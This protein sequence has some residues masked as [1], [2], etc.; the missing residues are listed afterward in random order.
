M[1]RRARS[2]WS[3]CSESFQTGRNTKR[4]KASSWP[5]SNRSPA[6]N[7]RQG[8]A[9]SGHRAAAEVREGH[10]AAHATD[11]RCRNEDRA[12]EAAQAGRYAGGR[13]L[14][15]RRHHAGRRE[16][17]EHHGEG[18][19]VTFWL[20]VASIEELPLVL[21]TVRELADRVGGRVVGD[22]NGAIARI[23]GIEESTADTLTFATDE[24]I[25][26]PRSR[27]GLPPCWSMPRSCSAPAIRANRCWS[28][29]NARHALAQLLA[30]QCARSARA[31]RSGIRVRSS[32]PMPSSAPTSTS[33]RT[34]TSGAGQGSGAASVIGAGAYV[35]DA[36][37][38]RSVGLAPSAREPAWRAASS[39]IASCCMPAASS[40]AK[41]SAGRSST[42]ARAHSAGR[43]RRARR[44]RRDRC[45]HLRRPGANRQHA[46]RQG[47]QDRQSRADRAQLPHRQT[48]RAGCADRSGRFDRRRR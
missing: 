16:E 17:H 45:E 12:A 43:Q 15:R 23:A 41:A 7:Q 9:A 29:E 4:T 20:L 32:N 26:P 13:R 1:A 21:G 18:D 34:R 28:C 35:G 47:H 40:A 19:A 6:K 37:D 30:A 44:R 10:R 11:P 42:A 8:E 24:A 27:A 31:A 48:L 22:G 3:T 36:S 5:T 2:D 46:H 38:R 33:A 39:A 25:S 14:R